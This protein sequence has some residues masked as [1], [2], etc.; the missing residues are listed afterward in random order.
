[1]LGTAIDEHILPI[2]QTVEEHRQNG[3]ELSV[4]QTE[5]LKKILREQIPKPRNFPAYTLENIRE[6]TVTWLRNSD[7]FTFNITSENIREELES[8]TKSPLTHITNYPMIGQGAESIVF[9]IGPYLLKMALSLGAETAVINF[10]L[11]PFEAARSVA[12]RVGEET[13]EFQEKVDLKADLLK[14]KAPFYVGGGG[15]G[16]VHECGVNRNGLVKQFDYR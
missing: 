8:I 1:M 15:H 16:C 12:V 10:Y 4:A 13:Y 7:D 2:A 14:A 5:G 3:L 11:Q 6:D 9:D